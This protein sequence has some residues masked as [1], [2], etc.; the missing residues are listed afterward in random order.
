[1]NPTSKIAI[2][3]IILAVTALAMA[4]SSISSASAQSAMIAPS[5]EIR[6]PISSYTKIY[7]N[8]TIEIEI[9]VT[10]YKDAPE[11]QKI[12]Y[13][14]DG[15][16]LTIANMTKGDE[17]D[18]FADNKTGYVCYGRGV[19]EN[20]PEGNY[21]LLVHVMDANGKTIGN[22]VNF[23]ID[24]DYKPP[25]LLSPQNQTDYSSQVPLT[26]C[27]Y[28]GIVYAYYSLNGGAP[29]Y[30]T[31]NTT[32]TGLSDGINQLNFL[33]KFPVTTYGFE[34]LF[35]FTEN[36]SNLLAEMLPIVLC[37]VFILLI[38]TAIVLHQK[39]KVKRLAK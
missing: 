6:S 18:T 5:V 2:K 12:Y 34:S 32:L 24:L 33:A 17:L 38:V 30:V 37:A 28:E 1:M 15:R 20:L 4:I 27:V 35:N 25:T 39:R 9:V 31:G 29:V 7:S 13:S 23:T 3:S 11:I 8:T 14:L 22:R 26:F 21:T 19:L 16:T 10:N 36:Q